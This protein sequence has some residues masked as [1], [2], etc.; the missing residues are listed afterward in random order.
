MSTTLAPRPTEDQSVP[1]APDVRAQRS[2]RVAGVLLALIPGALTAYLA[3]RTG[4]YY[5]Q[6]YASVVVVLAL[7]LG[8]AALASRRPFGGLGPTLLVACGALVLLVAWTWFSSGWSDA[9]FRALLESQ[10]TALYLLTLLFCGSFVRRQ[11]AL[12]LAVVGVAIAIAGVCAAALATRLYPDVFTVSSTL[13][14]QRLSFPISYWNSLGLFAGIGLVLLLH[15][16]S[17]LRAHPA[18]RVLGAAAV[19]LAAVT[20]YFTF[21]RGAAG[22]IALGVVAYLIVGRSWGMVGG[23]LAAAPTT[24]V[25]L[26]AAYGADLL[27]THEPTTTAAA[28]QGHGVAT[29]VIAACAG[30]AVLRAA[31]VPLDHRLSAIRPRTGA[32]RRALVTG[33]IVTAVLAGVVAVALDAPGQVQQAYDS[34]TNP[35]TGTVAG[36]D[37]RTRFREVTLSGRQDHWNVALDSFRA[38]RLAGSGAGTFETEWLRHRPIPGETSEAH[39]LYLEVLGELGIVG[40]LLL[41]TALGAILVGLAVRARGVRR[42]I[43]GA[44]FAAFLMWAVHAGVDWDWELPAVGLGLFALAGLGLARP[45][46]STGAQARLVS[47]LGFRL[48]V[49]GAC[50]LVGITAVRAVVADAAL[51]SSVAAKDAGQCRD[52][53]ADAR[54]ALS[55]VATHPKAYEVLAYCDLDAGRAAAAVTG[56][57]EAARLDPGH[58]RYRYGLAIARAAAGRDPAPDLRLARQL[59]PFGVI[60]LGGAAAEM[61]DAPPARW[62][63]LARSAVRP[64]D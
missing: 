55:A 44:L 11:G 16:A 27:A 7:A 20:I 21:S 64:G 40:F 33:A 54:V 6:A 59:N 32:A 43:Y 8:G 23:L 9:P 4:G 3:F 61:E 24:A 36:S 2:W 45:K 38:N 31:L 48:A 50:L 34:F 12:S 52:A 30:A 62:K 39:S 5:A 28:A 14:P 51:D 47:S 13:A 17:D 22:A 10:R 41:V 57:Q 29:W 56:M 49:A 42:P 18:I 15:L 35:E 37:A 26:F 58:W 19:P 1:P 46:L 25:A 53:R 60:L 63:R